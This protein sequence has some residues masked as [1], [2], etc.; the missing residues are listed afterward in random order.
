MKAK[1]G[2]LCS[3][4]SWGGLEMNHVRNAIWMKERGHQ[5]VLLCVKNTPIEKFALSN[6]IE[7]T[8]IEKHKKYYDFKKAKILSEI[9]LYFGTNPSSIIFQLSCLIYCFMVY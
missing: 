8:H 9:L 2:Y 4:E 3:S 5:V 7:V 6:N 1:L